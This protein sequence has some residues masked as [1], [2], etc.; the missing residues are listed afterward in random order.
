MDEAM[1]AVARECLEGADQDQMNFP[2]IVATLMAA[3]FEG[4]QVDFRAGRAS[5]YALDG[6][7]VV[8]PSGRPAASI[9]AVFD[10]AVVRAAIGEA[11]AQRPGY[12]YRDFCAKVA[13]GGCAAYLVS[14][15]GRCAIYVGRTG[16]LHVE[17]FPD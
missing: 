9:A 3:G 11:Q 5:Y 1:I 8:L 13:A 16:A 2:V 6:D 17:R 14:F 10:P 12:R 15:S 7:C 4:Y